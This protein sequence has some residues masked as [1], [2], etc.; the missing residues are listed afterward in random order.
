MFSVRKFLMPSYVKIIMI[1]VFIQMNHFRRR[2]YSFN[3][4]SPYFSQCVTKVSFSSFL[5]TKLVYKILIIIVDR[6]INIYFLYSNGI[7]EDKGELHKHTKLVFLYC[8]NKIWLIHI[9]NTQDIKT[10]LR[11][12]FYYKNYKILFL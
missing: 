11:K 2:N 8:K 1:L 3:F 10:S 9:Y 7:Q 5:Q 4:V 6:L 12:I